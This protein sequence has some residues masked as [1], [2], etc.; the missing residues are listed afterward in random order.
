MW[1]KVP[2]DKIIHREVRYPFHCFDYLCAVYNKKQHLATENECFYEGSSYEIANDSENCTPET[3]VRNKP[4]CFLKQLRFKI[5][6]RY[7][8]FYV[9]ND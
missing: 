3:S 4:Q 6:A 1:G 9:G 2:W 8:C 5:E 7:F